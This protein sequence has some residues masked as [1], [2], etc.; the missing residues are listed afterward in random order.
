MTET[1][2]PKEE[3]NLFKQLKDLKVIFD[4]GARTDIDYFKLW[5]ES[6]HHLFEPNPEFCEVLKEKVGDKPN[7][8]INNFGLGDK[9]CEQGYQMGNQAFIDSLSINNLTATQDKILPIKTLDTYI[10]EKSIE[11]IDFLKM[12]TEGYE[13]KV[14]L[15]ATNWFHIIKFIQYE[16][17][18]KHN[19]LMIKGL[20]SE[21]FDTIDIGYRNVF[22]MNKK[23]VGEEETT[24]LKTYIVENKLCELS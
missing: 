7:V 17:W 20:L 23:L 2:I 5:P 3:L 4:V 6:E 15:G 12:D 24:R 9:E 13:L 16:H 18:G 11:R 22:C 1:P 21:D 10:R 14:L 8:F 19:N